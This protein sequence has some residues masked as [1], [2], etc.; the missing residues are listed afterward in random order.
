MRTHSDGREFLAPRQEDF[1]FRATRDTVP[2]ESKE[3]ESHWFLITLPAMEP[4]EYGIVPPD[5]AAASHTADDSAK[6]YTF[7]L[8]P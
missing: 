1:D 8:V 2:F 7:R 3:V 6:M 5:V 4:G